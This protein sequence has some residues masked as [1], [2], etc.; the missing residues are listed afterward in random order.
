MHE[1]AAVGLGSDLRQKQREK[2]LK[3]REGSK[4]QKKTMKG[5]A[6]KIAAPPPAA[7]ATS[8]SSSGGIRVGVG[9]KRAEDIAAS[10]R[11]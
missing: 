9:A 4:Q 8:I 6:S 2:Q 11:R 3:H 5:K 1:A 10:T 7:V